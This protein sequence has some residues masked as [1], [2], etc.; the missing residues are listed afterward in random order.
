[1]LLKMDQQTLLI[2]LSTTFVRCDV[3]S[4]DDQVR[5]FS[6]AE[7]FSPSGK[8]HFVVPNAGIAPQDDVFSFD[9]TVCPEIFQATTH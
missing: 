8:I 7:A 3:T 9:G 1:M 5:L 6:A 4:W 2:S